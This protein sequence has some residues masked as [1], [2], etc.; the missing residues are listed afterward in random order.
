MTELIVQSLFCVSDCSGGGAKQAR[1]G[2]SKAKAGAAKSA[3]RRGTGIKSAG[4]SITQ[5]KY[6]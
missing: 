3:T 5:C 2:C 6:T 4:I 1:S